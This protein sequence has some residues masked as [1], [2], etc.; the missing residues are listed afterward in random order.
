MIAAFDSCGGD[1]R[2]D[3]NFGPGAVLRHFVFIVI[4]MPLIYSKWVKLVVGC[5]HRPLKYISIDS[6]GCFVQLS[7]DSDIEGH[8]NVDKKSLIRF[9]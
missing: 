2:Y 8:P 1:C 4:N 9:I 5:S 3:L 6:P 7:D